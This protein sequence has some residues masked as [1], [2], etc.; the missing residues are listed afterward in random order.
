MDIASGKALEDIMNIKYRREKR[1]RNLLYLIVAII[2]MSSV[3][4]GWRGIVQINKR[5]TI[6]L[7]GKVATQ[8]ELSAEKLLQVMRQPEAENDY[9][10][11]VKFLA[12]EGYGDSTK[13]F[14]T[15][16]YYKTAFIGLLVSGTMVLKYMIGPKIH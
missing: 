1:A 12:S 10:A 6:V 15:M 4:I 8:S 16:G 3:F 11:G 9:F 13:N 14:L 2:W 5:C 7:F